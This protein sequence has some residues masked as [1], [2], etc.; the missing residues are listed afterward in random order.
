MWGALGVPRAPPQQCPGGTFRTSTRNGDGTS[1]SE[2]SSA[3]CPINVAG[4]FEQK[5]NWA[6]NMYDLRGRQITRGDAGN[7]E[8]MGGGSS[9]CF[10]HTHTRW[11]K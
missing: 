10:H 6:F 2:F 3:R 8:D 11:Y 9:Q 1:S 5:L 7:H 4:N